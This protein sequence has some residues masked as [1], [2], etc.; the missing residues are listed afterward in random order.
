[1]HYKVPES[2]LVVI[3]TPALEVL[4]LERLPWCEQVHDLAAARREDVGDQAAMAAPRQ[5][6]GAH[7]AWAGQRE[8]FGQCVLPGGGGHPGGVAPKGGNP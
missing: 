1:M 6:L 7:E 2:V 8:C 3:H 4:L 5:R